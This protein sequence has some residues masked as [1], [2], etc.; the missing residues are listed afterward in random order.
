MAAAISSTQQ[1]TNLMAQFQ[2][3]REESDHNIKKILLDAKTLIPTQNGVKDLSQFVGF[4]Q[5]MADELIGYKD[6]K[7]LSKKASEFLES[8]NQSLATRQEELNRAC[9]TLHKAEGNIGV[10]DLFPSL[11]ASYLQIELN[12]LKQEPEPALETEEGALV[13]AETEGTVTLDPSFTLT[14]RNALFDSEAQMSS[15]PLKEEEV[16]GQQVSDP[17]AYVP[18]SEH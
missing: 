17:A 5:F 7:E 16:K 4:R 6:L 18:P 13:D 11:K 1:L 8:I 12:R 3:E 14:I 15:S 2:Q 9:F 10:I